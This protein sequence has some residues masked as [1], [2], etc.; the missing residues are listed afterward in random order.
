[1]LR[2]ARTDVRVEPIGEP[3]QITL[4]CRERAGASGRKRFSPEDGPKGIPYKGITE[5][6]RAL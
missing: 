4:R 1:M 5:V 6:N 3:K 2:V